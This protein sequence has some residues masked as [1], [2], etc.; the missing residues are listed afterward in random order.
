MEENISKNF[1]ILTNLIKSEFN[2]QSNFLIQE[3]S[4][5]TKNIK[6]NT[7]FFAINKGNNF[8]EDA[9]KSGASLVI[10]DNPSTV[11]LEKYKNKIIKVENT[12]ETMQELAKKYRESLNLKVIGITGSNGKTS[13]KDIVSSILS[14]KYKVYKTQ[15]NFNNFIGLPFTILSLDDEIEIAVLEMGMSSFGEIDKLSDISRPDFAIITNIGESHIEFL[16]TRENIFKAKTEIFKYL[17]ESKIYVNGDDDLLSKTKCKKIGFSK[18]NDFIISNY[19]IF[20]ENNF[21]KIAFNLNNENYSS[22]LIGKHSAINISL[23][24]ALCKNF[25]LTYKDISNSL[26]NLK[27]TE[28]RFEINYLETNIIVNDAYNASPTSMINAIENFS[29]LFNDKYK[30]AVLGDMLEL[31]EKSSNYHIEILEKI[32]NLNIDR[33]FLYGN[34]MLKSY[35]ILNNL[36]DKFTCFNSL[37]EIDLELKNIKNTAILF[38]SSHGIGLGDYAKELIN[39]IKFQR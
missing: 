13:T 18:N 22:N 4:M 23:A 34:E 19:E 3:V 25:D 14:T 2:I 31:G 35:T 26:L 30:I 28:M 12:I 29:Q 5:N 24:I 1:R 9:I 39:S 10:A 8:I 37:Q 7:L 11:L 32:Q 33:V 6:N 38:K 16:K 21:Y 27:I 15:G 20:K 36:N 17:D